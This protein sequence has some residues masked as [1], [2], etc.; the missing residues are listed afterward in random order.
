MKPVRRKLVVTGALGHIGS[1]FLRI[2]RPG[3][4]DEVVLVDDLSTQ[5]YVSLFDLPAGIPF[6]FHEEDILDADLARRI[7]G[8]RAVVHLAAVA[9]P[10]RGLADPGG[11][12]RINLEGTLRVAR[13]CV[14]AGA[15]LFFPSSTSVYGEALP[16]AEGRV[17][18]SRDATALRPRGPYAEGKLRAEK[19]LA[20]LARAEGL[21]FVAARFGT[22]F[23]VSPGMRFHTAVNRF[24]WQ[25]CAGLPLTVWRA[26]LAQRRPYLDVGDAAAAIDFMLRRDL[27]GGG[28]YNV[29]TTD[30]T[31]DEVVSI[32]RRHVPDLEARLVDSP[33]MTESSYVVSVARIRAAGFEAAG[34]LER[35]I[36][37]TVA[38]L[39]NMRAFP[40][41]EA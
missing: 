33:L 3:D 17:D 6:R 41:P 32:L 14:A 29:V 34:S 31:V 19:A 40:M 10:G 27:F 36:A 8:A 16:D 2:L 23:G 39:R 11:V 4:W 1:R 22:I 24:A 30:A 5:R 9:D 20:D 21:R 7:D 25:A 28:V 15:G 35:G 18:E 13:A 12:E 38:R 37:D 26:A